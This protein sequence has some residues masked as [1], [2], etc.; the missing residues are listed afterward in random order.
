ML[1]WYYQLGEI[2]FVV[3]LY[4]ILQFDAH[5]KIK[6]DICPSVALQ[7]PVGMVYQQCGSF[8]PATCDN[9]DATAMCQGGCAEGCFCP[10]GQV[11]LDDA[12][13]DPFVCT[14]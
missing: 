11:L 4:K 13:V 10:D 9:I 6:T 7:C 12:C 5:T 14:G 3:R 1:V 2:L 8:C